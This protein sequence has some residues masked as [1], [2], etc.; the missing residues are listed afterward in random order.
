MTQK[1]KFGYTALGA[2]IMLVGIGV[3][4]IVFAAIGC[5]ERWCVW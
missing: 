2:L 1:Q 5:T 3:G 4:S